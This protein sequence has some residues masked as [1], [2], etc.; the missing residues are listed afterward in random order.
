MTSVEGF[1]GSTLSHATLWGLPLPLTS[2]SASS[3]EALLHTPTNSGQMIAYILSSEDLN[4]DGQNDLYVVM[5][6]PITEEINYG[7]YYGPVVDRSTED[8][9]VEVSGEFTGLAIQ[10]VGDLDGDGDPDVVFRAPD[11]S[12]R[13]DEGKIYLLDIQHSGDVED[14]SF[15]EITG[16]A[17]DDAPTFGRVDDVDGDGTADLVV[18]FD[19]AEPDYHYQGW[20]GVFYGPFTGNRQ[21]ADRDAVIWGAA[22][23]SFAGSYAGVADLNGNGVMDLLV[24]FREASEAESHL[25]VF[26]DGL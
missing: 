4:I 25:D 12:T 16:G 15:A 26:F 5:V 9:D 7:L 13:T 20:V 24:G 10:C 22:E 21:T 1:D 8:A 17:H 23:Y 6:N 2:T 3:A 14:L 19:R 18:G 11:D